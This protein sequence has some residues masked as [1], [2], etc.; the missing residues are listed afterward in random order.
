MRLVLEY[1]DKGSLHDALAKGAFLQSSGLCVTAIIET[2]DD[3][4]KAMVH[5]HAAGVLH[6]DLK[7]RFTHSHP[8]QKNRSESESLLLALCHMSPL[9]LDTPVAATT[10][11]QQPACLWPF[12]TTF[13][14]YSVLSLQARNIMLK[15][16]GTEG[17]GVVAKVA[18]FGL[19]SQIAPADAHVS[20]M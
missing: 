1:C 19:S 10:S 7:V 4:A 2:A 16:S 20:S 6:S 15:S 11:G 18:D 3:V 8:E 13:D 5:M 9:S 14:L 12:A 17:R